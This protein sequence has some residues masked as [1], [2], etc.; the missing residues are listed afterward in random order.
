MIQEDRIEMPLFLDV[1]RVYAGV[2]LT[3]YVMWIHTNPHMALCLRM[4]C[5]V[6]IRIYYML[7]ISAYLECYRSIV[8]R[9]W[10][11]DSLRAPLT[12]LSGRLLG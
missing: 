5:N 3:W 2:K 4:P 10:V 8:D 12:P 11:L 7:Y 1:G 6:H 9:V